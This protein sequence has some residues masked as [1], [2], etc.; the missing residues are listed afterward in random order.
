MKFRDL[1]NPIFVG[2]YSPEAE[3]KRTLL[4]DFG[5]RFGL[6]TLVE[7]GT[8]HGGTVMECIPYFQEIY[9]IELEPSLVAKATKR[10]AEFAN[11]R[12]IAGSSGEKLSELLDTLGGRP[13]LFWLDAHLTG[14]VSASNGD[15]TTPELAAIAEKSPQSLVVIDDV[16]PPSAVSGRYEAPDAPVVVPQGWTTIFLHGELVLHA[17]GYDIPEKF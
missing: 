4:I 15:Q 9:T 14:G 11:V 1:N 3:W 10:F 17:G 7:T 16:K 6:N 12:V 2:E 13:V 8:S 5:K